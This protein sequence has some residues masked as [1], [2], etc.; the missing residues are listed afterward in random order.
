MNYRIERFAGLNQSTDEHQIDGRYAPEARNVDIRDGNLC[1]SSGYQP[2]TASHLPGGI[3]S[4]AVYYQRTSTGLRVRLVA[5]NAAGVYEWAGNQ[6]VVRH[7]G[8]GEAAASALNYQY[9]GEDILLLADG[10]RGVLQ[11]DGGNI[12]TPL[13]GAPAKFSQLALH[14]ERIW[15]SGIADEPDSV[16]WSRA[17]E[18]NDW[19]GD[20]SNPDAAGGV[21]NIPTFNG[22]RVIALRTLFNDVLVFKDDDLYRVVGT[23]PGNYEVVRV[24]GIVGPIAPKTIVNAGDLCYFLSKDGLC[25]YN[26]IS[27]KPLNDRRAKRFFERINPAAAMNACA[28]VHRDVLYL[29]APMGA[30]TRNDGV[31]EMDL[32][33]GGCMERDGIPAQYFLS[34]QDKLLFAG[35]DGLIYQYGVG[36]TRNGAPIIAWW[37]TPWIDLNHPSREKYVESVSMFASGMM[38]LGFE[39]DRGEIERTYN[40]GTTE[41]PVRLRLNGHGKRFRLTINNVAGSRFQIRGGL[42]ITLD[43]L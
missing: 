26:G 43:D 38:R 27:A 8:A 30:S 22:G 3:G 28:A 21:V 9:N 13:P 11:W 17:F 33:T 15:G 24:H 37:R 5:V 34:L 16:Y 23:Y 40:L 20:P 35:D 14:Y 31:L 7:S 18:P 36:T 32:T 41:R 12:M 25:A 4:L 29:A 2:Y 42:D 10:V 1:V 19:S 6:W 39:T